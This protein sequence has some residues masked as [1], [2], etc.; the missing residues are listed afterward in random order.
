MGQ[1]DGEAIGRPSK[2]TDETK[3]RILAAIRYGAS[4]KLAAEYAGISE[5]TLHRWLTDPGPEHQAFRRELELV[6]AEVK[7]RVVSS[8]HRMS[9]R[10]TRAA[11]IWLSR[12]GGD[13]WR[14]VCPNCGFRRPGL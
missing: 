9:S 5:S 8:L 7:V 13:E 6:V 2:L 4:K 3:E 12:F 14:P 11:E 1:P 10:N